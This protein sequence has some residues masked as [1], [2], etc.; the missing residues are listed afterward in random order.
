VASCPITV[1]VIAAA[2]DAEAA[3]AERKRAENAA[4][5]L[6]N[7]HERALGAHAWLFGARDNLS[8]YSEDLVDGASPAAAARAALHRAEALARDVDEARGKIERDEY[9]GCSAETKA[10]AM[11]TLAPLL[12]ARAAQY[13]ENA[14]NILAG[15][16]AMGSPGQRAR[17]AA[18]VVPVNELSEL[19]GAFI[20]GIKAA[21]LKPLK[22]FP[23]YERMQA[24]GFEHDADEAGEHAVEYSTGAVTEYPAPAWAAR[25][26]ILAALP[27]AQVTRICHRAHCDACGKSYDEC[28]YS[29]RVAVECPHGLTAVV[30]LADA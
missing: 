12:A 4:A 2:L 18:G 22:N 5:A 11:E 29:L 30:H 3:A 28:A 8:Y 27:N 15:A 14:K 20:S 26:S 24:D 10:I 6:E 16:L 7:L 13:E 9:C 1:G 25:A 21:A 19:K 17:Y 23:R